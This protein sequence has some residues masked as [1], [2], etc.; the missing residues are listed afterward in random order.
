MTKKLSPEEF[1]ELNAFIS[2][3]LVGPCPR[4]GSHNTHDLGKIPD[5]PGP[6]CPMTERYDD[7][8]IGHCDDCGYLWCLECGKEISEEDIT[9]CGMILCGHYAICSECDIAPCPYEGMIDKC[10]KIREWKAGRKAPS[11]KDDK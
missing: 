8:T 10:P 2:N 1:V 4:C 5:Y 6:Y 7:P 9:P 11:Q 3:L